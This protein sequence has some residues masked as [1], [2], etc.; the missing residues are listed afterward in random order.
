MGRLDS[1]GDAAVCVVLAAANYPGTPRAGDVIF[2]L[3]AG[4][5]YTTPEGVLV[6]HAGTRRRGGQGDAEDDLVTSG[7]RVLGVTARGA[8]LVQA[9]QHAYDVIGTDPGKIHFRG[10]HF[11]KDIGARGDS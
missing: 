1:V 5:G 8:D 4:G 9:R 7:G 3:P 6:F 10:M 2:G 11:R